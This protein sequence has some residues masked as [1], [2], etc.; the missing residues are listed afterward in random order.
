MSGG[1]LPITGTKSTLAGNSD[2]WSDQS[3][4]TPQLASSS[5]QLH[6][7]PPAL[8]GL[9][10]RNRGQLG[11]SFRGD[12]TMQPQTWFQWPESFQISSAIFEVPPALLLVAAAVLISQYMPPLVARAVIEAATRVHFASEFSEPRRNTVRRFVTNMTRVAIF[13]LFA[14]L[15]LALFVDT[16]GLLTFLGFFTAAF[17]LAVRPLVS[18]Y[19]SG[20][21]FLLEDQY[22]I[23]DDIEVALVKGTVLELNIR[24]TLLI[25]TSGEVYRIPNG[26]IRIVRN[27]TR[28]DFGLATVQI[29]VR[30]C[31]LD[32]TTQLLD[33][34]ASDVCQKIPALVEAPEVLMED[35]TLSDT[36][37][38]TISAKARYGEELHSKRR[39]LEMVREALL[40]GGVTANR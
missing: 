36:V 39:L 28:G 3:Q 22:D 33:E 12:R 5:F 21:I 24:T 18:D 7:N 25:S 4:V 40:K 29:P 23:G 2:E 1:I 20:L 19:V 35:G 34:L 16:G 31:D 30:N 27:F 38:V 32:R 15:I 11:L 17:G 8:F 6:A 10:F 13:A 14:V 37:L 26:E 9:S